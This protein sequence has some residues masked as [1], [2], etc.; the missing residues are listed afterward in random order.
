MTR[1][2]SSASG[3]SERLKAEEAYHERV[4]KLYEE[5]TRRILTLHQTQT[6]SQQQ[7][8]VVMTRALE[9]LV[10]RA[11]EMTGFA[12]GALLN[13]VKLSGENLLASF[14]N[15]LGQFSVLMGSMAIAA[16]QVL[17]AL[18]SGSPA[19]LFTAGLAMILIGGL[20]KSF[21]A[22]LKGGSSGSSSTGSGSAGTADRS[23][24]S[25]NATPASSKSETDDASR[26]P[27]VIYYHF[28]G[29][30]YDERALARIAAT[31]LNR[32]AGRTAPAI[33]RR[34]LEGG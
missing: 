16:S 2:S 15:M 6:R 24:S 19:A 22:Q 3:T 21:A 11:V 5:T 10:E 14:L 27:T 18:F 30:V 4:R 17:T 13:G 12:V 20:L 25:S 33:L 26:E 29:G 1:T 31:A 32:H 8:A 7:A 34:A 23:A 9:S 28:E